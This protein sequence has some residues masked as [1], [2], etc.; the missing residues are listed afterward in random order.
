[1]IAVERRE[2]QPGVFL[3]ALRTRK[4]KTGCLSLH[5]ITPLDPA[6]VSVHALLPQLLRRGTELC[7]G[8]E[9]L[10]ARL[11]SY[12]G[13]YLEPSVRK[14]GECQCIGF[15]GS[16]VDDAF[17]P[18]KLPLLEKMAALLGEVLLHP[19]TQNGRF[20]ADWLE[21]ERDQL[22]D[23]ILAQR[24]DKMT[25]AALRL[26]QLMCKDEPYGVS[27][28]GTEKTVKAIRLTKVF[29]TYRELLESAPI[30]IFY[31]GSASVDRVER[32]LRDGLRDLSPRRRDPW[33]ETKL[34]RHAPADAPRTFTDRMDVLQ[35]K[36]GMGFRTGVGPGDEEYPA[37]LI[38][39]AVYG[40]TATSKLFLNVRERLSLCYYAS[41]GI[42]RSKGIMTVQSGI[43]FSNYDR[44][45][46]EILAQL[47][48]CRRGEFDEAELNAARRA[49]INALR[50]ATDAQLRLEDFYLGQTLAGLDYGPDEMALLLEDVTHEQVT[51]AARRVE[52]DSVYFLTGTEEPHEGA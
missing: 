48:A 14:V 13:A 16:F 9:Q 23:R 38:F 26:I 29:Q 52:L 42:H 8:M 45:K 36:L 15:V 51:E 43:E 12:Y 28:I 34:I 5:L 3:T 21:G 22:L 46:D 10:A 39:N 47:E 17:V 1:M 4:F 37:L 49:M 18:D 19:A 27:S 6:T 30:E 33:P 32:A 41:S 31:C 24:N 25:Y 40:G 20:Y 44:A 50:T 7:P 35:G 11:D 2:L